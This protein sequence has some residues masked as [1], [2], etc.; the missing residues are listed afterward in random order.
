MSHRK[1]TISE[2]P[3]K[4]KTGSAC[5]FMTKIYQKASSSNRSDPTPVTLFFF[6]RHF[7]AGWSHLFNL[8]R[9]AASPVKLNNLDCCQRW[10]S[11][12]EDAITHW[13]SLNI[14]N[15]TSILSKLLTLALVQKVVANY[16]PKHKNLEISGITFALYELRLPKQLS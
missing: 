16:D 12:V 2:I 5:I 9:H 15:D 10:R 8:N 1:T 6:A 14:K 13:P 11:W 3:K 4:R 7:L